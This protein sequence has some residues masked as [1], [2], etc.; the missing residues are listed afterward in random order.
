MYASSSRQVNILFKYKRTTNQCSLWVAILYIIMSMRSGPNYPHPREM[1]QWLGTTTL[2]CIHTSHVLQSLHHQYQHQWATV[3]ELSLLLHYFIP[4]E[5]HEII[6]VFTQWTGDLDCA[7]NSQCFTRF[8]LP[9]PATC[10]TSYSQVW[11]Q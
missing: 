6:A 7:N 5:N 9:S 3:L 2:P 1:P 11:Q 8:I 4:S 10:H